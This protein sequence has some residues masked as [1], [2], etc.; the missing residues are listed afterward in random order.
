MAVGGSFSSLIS[1]SSGIGEGCSGT[2]EAHKGNGACRILIGSGERE[3]VECGGQKGE[4]LEAEVD[5]WES[6]SCRAWS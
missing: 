2:N 6:W 4:M 5:I 3:Q 1:P